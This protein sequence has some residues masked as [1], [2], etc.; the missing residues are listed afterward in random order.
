MTIEI[1]ECFA[2]DMTMNSK[3]TRYYLRKKNQVIA[4]KSS[5]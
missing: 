2:F 4:F 3:V 5:Q 1:V